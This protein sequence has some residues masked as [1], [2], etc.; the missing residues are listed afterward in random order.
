MRFIRWLIGLP[1]AAIIVL[2]ALSNQQMVDF[3]FWP[4]EIRVSVGVYLAV[5]GP[6]LLGV[7]LGWLAP[8][9]SA[10]RSGSRIRS[11]ARRIS[12]LE[13]ELVVAKK[14]FARAEAELVQMKKGR[15]ADILALPA[16]SSPDKDSI[17]SKL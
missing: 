15:D 9:L 2:F 17:L 6:F 11:Q 7:F 4:F 5:L 1:V 14:S 16:Q 10:W 12:V 3:G 13:Q 8:G